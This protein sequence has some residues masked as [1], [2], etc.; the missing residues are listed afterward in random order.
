MPWI[1][2]HDGLERFHAEIT[3][4]LEQKGSADFFAQ[5]PAVLK[6]GNADDRQA[7]IDRFGKPL[8]PLA[9]STLKKRSRGGLLGGGSGPP[10][11]PRGWGSR[12]VTN[13]VV[14]SYST[15]GRRVFEC[16]WTGMLTKKGRPWL[17]YHILGK[18]FNPVRN[19]AGASPTPWAKLKKL[20][21][22]WKAG[23]FRR[24]A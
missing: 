7:G 22:D 4:V 6:R 21:E 9:A 11:A 8:A 16:G 13:F 14:T 17:P 15:L 10:L 23:L 5:V 19:I 1:L 2:S 20:F 12:V 3:E 24:S 18:G